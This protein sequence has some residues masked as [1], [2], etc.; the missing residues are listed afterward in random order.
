MLSI[1]HAFTSWSSKGP[2]SLLINCMTPITFAGSAIDLTGTASMFSVLQ[3]NFL[4]TSGLNRESSYAF[5]MIWCSLCKQTH[6]AML[7]SE[8]GILIDSSVPVCTRVHSCPESSST[9]KML[10]MLVPIV[11]LADCMTTVKISSSSAI[12]LSRSASSRSI[13]SRLAMP[14]RH[15]ATTPHAAPAVPTTCTSLREAC[16]A[17][18]SGGSMKHLDADSTTPPNST[19]LKSLN[20]CPAAAADRPERL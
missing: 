20:T 4:S 8:I 11:S 13:V 9:R 1:L 10:P 7:R 16:A 19:P 5:G 14:S 6:P 17:E 12:R 15:P 2:A 18:N 3:P